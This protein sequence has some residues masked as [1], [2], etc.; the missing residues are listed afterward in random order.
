MTRS[1][2]K[3]GIARKDYTERY[4]AHI[5]KISHRQLFQVWSM[6]PNYSGPLAAGT[7]D[8]IRTWAAENG[9]MLTATNKL[10]RQILNQ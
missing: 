4:P 1:I 8:E 3:I 5:T 6:S 9:Y 10:G 7:I 2:I